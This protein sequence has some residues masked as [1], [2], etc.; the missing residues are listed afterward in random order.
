MPITNTSKN[1]SWGK[2]MKILVL[3]SERDWD[4]EE[5]LY[6]AYGKLLDKFPD[7]N[8]EFNLYLDTPWSRGE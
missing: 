2:P 1:N 8:I 6:D 4:I 5:E 7:K 3:M